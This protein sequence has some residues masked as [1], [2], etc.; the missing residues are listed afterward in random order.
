MGEWLIFG[1]VSDLDAASANTSTGPAV[2]PLKPAWSVAN[3]KSV[4]ITEMK[5]EKRKRSA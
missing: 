2:K 1:R 3:A 4:P 5:D